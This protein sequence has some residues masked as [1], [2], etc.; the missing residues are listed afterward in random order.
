MKISIDMP[1]VQSCAIVDCAYNVSEN[2]HARA[3]TIGDGMH[4]GCDTAFLDAPMRANNKKRIAGVGAC[5]VTSCMFNDDLE[6]NAENINV[7]LISN[8]INCMTFA[9]A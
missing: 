5:K 6:C 8:S 3:I 1:Q 7:G 4:P 9:K 2:C